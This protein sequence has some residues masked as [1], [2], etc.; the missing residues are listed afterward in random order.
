MGVTKLYV[1]AKIHMTIYLKRV[2]FLGGKLYLI[3]PNKKYEEH[4][5][6]GKAGLLIE[7]KKK[8]KKT[9]YMSD[10]IHNNFKLQ[11]VV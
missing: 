7:V 1:F 11:Y 8:K 6:L 5:S 3:N 10:L 2:H 4:E 9:P